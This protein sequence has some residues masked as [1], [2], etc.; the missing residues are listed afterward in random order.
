MPRK[1]AEDRAAAAWRARG[2]PPPPSKH[3]GRKAKAIW[4]EIVK[5]RPPDFFPISILPLLEGFCVASVAAR[6][7]AVAVEADPNDKATADVWISFAKVQATLATKLRLV[8]TASRPSGIHAEKGG[9]T[10]PLIG[11]SA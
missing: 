4:R 1:S 6:E 5:S 2:E 3:L 11:G 9:G 8:N 7:L 10:H